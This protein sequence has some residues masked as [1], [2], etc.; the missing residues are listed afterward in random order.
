MARETGGKC[1]LCRR[2]GTKL[3]LKGDRCMSTKCPMEGRKQSAPGQHGARMRRKVSEYGIQLREKQKVRRMYGV[4]ERQ[5]RNYYKAAARQKG[6]TGE[7]LLRLLERRLDNVVYRLGFAP[8]R[9]SARQIVGHRHVLVNG[10]IVDIA[11]YSVTVGDVVEV[12]EKSRG[13]DLVKSSLDKQ[14]QRD[15]IGWLELDVKAMRGVVRELPSRDTV[16]VPVEEQ[17]I[18]ELYSK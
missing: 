13:I 5:F 9:P 8:S 1:K 17:A 3:F 12:K 6:V 10:R 14:K 7:N 4:L 15:P 11:S 18:V 2:E 16:T